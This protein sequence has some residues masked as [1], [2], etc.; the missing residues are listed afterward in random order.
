MGRHRDCPSLEKSARLGDPA[1]LP[2]IDDLSSYSP[3]VGDINTISRRRR[4][5][6]PPVDRPA[7]ACISVSD[8]TESSTRQSRFSSVNFP[9]DP[10]ALEYA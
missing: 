5:G 9:V 3:P 4:S 8:V 2:I 1:P 6:C 10:D 7:M